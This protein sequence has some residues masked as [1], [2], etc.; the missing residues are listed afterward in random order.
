MRAQRKILLSM[1]ERRKSFKMINFRLCKDMVAKRFLEFEPEL[2]VTTIT[3]NSTGTFINE[4]SPVTCPKA[5]PILFI[6][7]WK[8][9]M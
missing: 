2:I 7:S 6:T 8:S 3:E 4:N 9:G 5:V 1:L